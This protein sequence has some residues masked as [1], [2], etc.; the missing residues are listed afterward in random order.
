MKGVGRIGKN[1]VFMGASAPK[2]LVALIDARSEALGWSRAQYMLAVIEW[3]CANG[4][5][6]IGRTDET[7]RS[8][9]MAKFNKQIPV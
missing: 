5:P 2:E 4:A 7:M 8:A 3:W 9:V 6:P 1:R